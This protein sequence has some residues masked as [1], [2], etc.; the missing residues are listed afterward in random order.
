MLLV[1]NL[2]CHL[3][4]VHYDFKMKKVLSNATVSNLFYNSK[5]VKWEYGNNICSNKSPYI[6]YHHIRLQETSIKTVHVFT[7]YGDKA[8]IF[9]FSVFWVVTLPV[10]TNQ[11][12]Y[13]LILIPLGN[14]SNTFT[15]IR[16]G[17]SR[18]GIKSDIS[19][20]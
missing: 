15:G 2:L 19:I 13:K 7:A 4:L 18:E 5:Y 12:Y 16:K 1:P 9:G 6:Y 20:G 17:K 11:I 3:R 8:Y 14:L 10:K